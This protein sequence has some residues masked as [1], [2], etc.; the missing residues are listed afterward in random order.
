MST[1]TS[2]ATS[3]VMPECNFKPQPYKV[4]KLRFIVPSRVAALVLHAESRNKMQS[5][6][7]D[8]APVPPPGGLDE[9][10]A[11]SLILVYSLHYV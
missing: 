7:A 6:T 10:Y 8:F 11:P 1:Q 3:P 2:N 9:T 4:S 5:E